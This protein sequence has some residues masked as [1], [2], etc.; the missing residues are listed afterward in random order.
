[1]AEETFT[2][3][4]SIREIIL[5]VGMIGTGFAAWYN[6]QYDIEALQDKVVGLKNS[7][8]REIAYEVAA[9]KEG[10]REIKA[11]LIEMRKEQ[12]EDIKVLRQAIMRSRSARR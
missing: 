7:L 8:Q 5:I 10:I 2:W 9:R 3:K 12:R 4:L 11:L 6:V 1:M